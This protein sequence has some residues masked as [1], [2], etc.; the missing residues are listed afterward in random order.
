LAEAIT[1]QLGLE[2]E[3]KESRGGV[4]E[5]SFG[6]ALIFSKKQEKRFPEH[7]EVIQQLKKIIQD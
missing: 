6:D 1:S 5:V 2:C 7:E 4:F 3:F